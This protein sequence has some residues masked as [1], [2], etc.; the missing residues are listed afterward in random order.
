MN[1]IYLDISATTPIDPQVAEFMHELQKKTYGNPSSIH[2]EGQAARA[3]VEKSRRQL[4]N[5]LRC[6]PEEIIFTSSGSETNN[7]VLIPPFRYQK[8]FKIL[9]KKKH[10]K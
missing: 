10:L 9:G 2:R 5:V 4:A 3:V 7:M 6:L 1:R 8:V